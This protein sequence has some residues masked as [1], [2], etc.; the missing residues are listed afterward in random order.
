MIF[1]LLRNRNE[2]DFLNAMAMIVALQ[3][4]LVNHILCLTPPTSLYSNE[5]RNLHS[6]LL[7]WIPKQGQITLPFYP[8]YLSVKCYDI[9]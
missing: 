9:G 6:A 2:S 1:I 7:E 8:S 4:P 3:Q 5:V